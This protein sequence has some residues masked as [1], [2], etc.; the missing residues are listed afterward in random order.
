VYNFLEAT[1]GFL[2]LIFKNHQFVSREPDITEDVQKGR[3]TM[4]ARVLFAQGEPGNLD[5][6]DNL[7]QI[8]RELIIPAS[9]QQK[10]FKGALV[11]RDVNTGKGISI[12]LWET[13]A[14]LRA[15]EASGYLQEQVDKGKHHF[16]A[17]HNQEVYEVVL[18]E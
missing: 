7:A 8:V 11:L 17:P 10:G 13:E 14:D 12:T 15:N 6:S 16:V 9:K 3:T 18:Q 2:F 5:K 1:K 4:Y